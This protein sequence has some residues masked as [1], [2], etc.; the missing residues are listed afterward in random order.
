MKFRELKICN[1]GN[2]KCVI[3][4]ITNMKFREIQKRTFS[5][6]FENYDYKILR[7]TDM[8]QEIELKDRGP[9]E[10]SSGF[11]YVAQ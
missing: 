3:L 1:S 2:Y 10:R 9:Q 8:V 4:K 6:H 7:I 5:K 11:C